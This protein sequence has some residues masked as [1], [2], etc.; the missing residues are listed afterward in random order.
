MIKTLTKHGNSWALI[1]D[2]PIMELM[3]L[4]PDTLVQ[5]EIH[6]KKLT[7]AAAEDETPQRDMA[8]KEATERAIKKYETT[9]RKLAE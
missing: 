8:V 1:L 6:G 5:L 4:T 7:V 2:K 9:L 3:D